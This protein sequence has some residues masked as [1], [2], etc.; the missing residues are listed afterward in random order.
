MKNL[1]DYKG[2]EMAIP[3]TQDTALAKMKAEKELYEECFEKK[4]IENVG[5]LQICYEYDLKKAIELGADVTDFPEKLN[6][7]EIQN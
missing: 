2:I 3:H 5:H 4:Q 7:L 1:E 6:Y